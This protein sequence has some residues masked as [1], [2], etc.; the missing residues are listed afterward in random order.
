MTGLGRAAPTGAGWSSAG[1]RISTPVHRHT[2]VRVK[3]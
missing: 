3:A 2:G 1:P